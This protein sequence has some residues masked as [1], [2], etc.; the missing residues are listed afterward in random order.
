M[1]VLIR[2]K[3][4]QS[5]ELTIA[6]RLMKEFMKIRVYLHL[7]LYLKLVRSVVLLVTLYFPF[8]FKHRFMLQ[9]SFPSV[10]NCRLKLSF[11]K[12]SKI[13]IIFLGIQKTV[14]TLY[15]VKC[16]TDC[17]RPLGIRKGVNVK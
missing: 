11:T 12:T 14:S 2:S 4:R 16:S 3:A 10:R 6:N 5:I 1:K 15:Q 8:H 17:F 7:A 13:C 9:I